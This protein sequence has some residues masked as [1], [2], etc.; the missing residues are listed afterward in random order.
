[1]FFCVYIYIYIYTDMI[2]F[3]LLFIGGKAIWCIANKFDIPWKEDFNVN[4]LFFIG[5]NGG[6]SR[7]GVFNNNYKWKRKAMLLQYIIIITYIILSKGQNCALKKKILIMNT[8][9]HWFKS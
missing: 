5:K 8:I 4:T 7:E 3:I 9:L 1:M 6:I 2:F